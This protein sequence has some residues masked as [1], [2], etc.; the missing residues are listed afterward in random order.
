MGTPLR[1][2]GEPLL[3]AGLAYLLIH[4]NKRDPKLITEEDW[5]AW[6]TKI[7]DDY[8][9]GFVDRLL[10]VAFTQNG[11]NN[12]SW[13]SGGG[14]EVKISEIFGLAKEGKNYKGASSEPRPLPEVKCAFYEDEPAV[15][16]IGRDRFPL[17]PERRSLNFTLNGSGYL[18]VS[19]WALGCILGFIYVAPLISGRLLVPASLE[20]QLLLRAAEALYH[21]YVSLLIKMAR[22]GGKLEIKNPLSRFGEV[23]EEILSVSEEGDEGFP[24]QAFYFS[25]SGQ[26][27]DAEIYWYVSAVQTFLRR[28]RAERYY[29]AWRAFLHSFWV[30]EEK[31]GG[32]TVPEQVRESLPPE[33]QTSSKS[34]SAHQSRNLI[35][36]VLPDLPEAA[37]LFIRFFFKGYAYRSLNLVRGYRRVA[38]GGS[39]ALP[40]LDYKPIWE[41]VELFV[42]VFLPSM[43]QEQI[44]IIK[45]LA[46]DLASLVTTGREPRAHKKLL[47]L[48]G[49]QVSRYDVWRVLLI[50][51]LRKALSS[52][53]K[54][55]FSLDEYL[56]L[57]ETAEGYPERNW[58]LARDL[59]QIALIEELYKQGYFEK[60]K[61]ALEQLSNHTEDETEIL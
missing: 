60:D 27:P 38:Y 25:N 28:V 14:R 20:P 56:T 39:L 4:S 26:D 22:E 57:F 24:I 15:I 7:E 46:A 42:E 9:G 11:F 8:K 37:P 10:S 3:D 30:V 55:L 54:L 52:E 44:D 5:R 35:Y 12:P 18:P 17:L 34:I 47:G 31:R 48:G 33:K 36:E 50:R 45:R 49:S 21:K 29:P 16:L 43:T 41:V 13:K 58:K 40:H 19:Q 32:L 6:L 2:L 51:L 59:L 53:G 23:L 1:W 61:A